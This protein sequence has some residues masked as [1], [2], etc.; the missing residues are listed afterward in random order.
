MEQVKDTVIEYHTLPGMWTKTGDIVVRIDRDSDT[1]WLAGPQGAVRR[2]NV[3]DVDIDIDDL[4]TAMVLLHE[5][6]VARN[7]RGDHTNR[8]RLDALT[9]W[10]KLTHEAQQRAHLE[11]LAS[12]DP[13]ERMSI[14]EIRDRLGP[15]L[16]LALLVDEAS[17]IVKAETPA[18]E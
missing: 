10:V 9:F 6:T 15:G 4:R 14:S 8:A 17:K 1:V 16:V 13:A 3:K 2:E 5:T 11:A 7:K 18:D 12:E